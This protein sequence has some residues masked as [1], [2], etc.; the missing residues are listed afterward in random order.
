MGLHAPQ[1]LYLM[2]AM[3]ALIILKAT[4]RAINQ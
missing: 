3:G 1:F 4:L 2:H